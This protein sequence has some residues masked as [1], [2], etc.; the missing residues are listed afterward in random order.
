MPALDVESFYGVRRIRAEDVDVIR[1]VVHDEDALSDRLDVFDFVALDTMHVGRCFVLFVQVREL[2]DIA[3]I[4]LPHELICILGRLLY[5]CEHFNALK[6]QLRSSAALGGHEQ[7]QLT[8]V[9][10]TSLL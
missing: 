3:Q 2:P 6:V 4:L 10:D 1:G 8:S 5:L 9:V 7:G